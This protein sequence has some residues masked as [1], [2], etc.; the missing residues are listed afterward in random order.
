LP[1]GPGLDHAVA[2]GYLDRFLTGLPVALY[3]TC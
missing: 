3:S 1:Y 2:T